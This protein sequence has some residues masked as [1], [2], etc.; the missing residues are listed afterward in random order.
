MQQRESASQPQHEAAPSGRNLRGPRWGFH[1]VCLVVALYWLWLASTPGY[2][3]AWYALGL[4]VLMLAAVWFVWVIAY[5]AQQ[6]RFSAWLFVAPIG[7]LL[8]VLALM[9]HAPLK[10]R[11]AFSA[12]AFDQ[13]MAIAPELATDLDDWSVEPPIRIGSYWITMVSIDRGTTS[14]EEASG[15]LCG[16]AQFVNAPNGVPGSDGVVSLGGA[17]Y[18]VNTGC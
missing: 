12:S 4:M 9:T 2:L 10:A 13:A 14:F 16:S 11:W 15:T 7:G 18:A 8:V 5:V 3:V 17:W 1:A 6:R